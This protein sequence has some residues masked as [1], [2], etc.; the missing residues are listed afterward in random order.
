M[1]SPSSSQPGQGVGFD[2][3]EVRTVF[4]DLMEFICC[5]SR[6]TPPGVWVA[7]TDMLLK[8]SGSPGVCA[9]VCSMLSISLC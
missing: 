9:H 1:P 2:Q 3:T 6:D 5:L 7:S 4:D 8:T